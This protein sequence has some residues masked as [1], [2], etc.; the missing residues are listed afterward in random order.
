MDAG[1]GPPE[2]RIGLM[3]LP[4]NVGPIDRIA[5]VVLGVGLAV[6]ALGGSVVAPFSYVVWI[7]AAIALVTGAIGFCPLY[8]LLGISTADNRL[9]LGRR[10]K[11]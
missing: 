1:K 10:S 6:V 8:F 2:Q 11:A 3:K 5:R 9:T 7:V 4:Q